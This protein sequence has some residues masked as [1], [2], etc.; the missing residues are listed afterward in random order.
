MNDDELITVVRD[1]FTSVHS[2]TPL[3][4]IVHRSH[5][6]RFR[7]WVPRLAGALAAAAAVGIA[8]PVLLPTS[9]RATHLPVV[10]L[11]AAWTVTRQA[12]GNVSVTIREFRDPAGLQSRLRADGVPASVIFNEHRLNPCHSYRPSGN[13]RQLHSAV[14]SIAVPGQPQGHAATI[15]IH[16]SALPNGSGVQITTRQSKVNVHLVAAN[17]GCTGE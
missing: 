17:S 13:L 10:Q 2:A 9:H 1:A 11:A 5:A 12:D 14:S 8:V 15:V 6:M 4:Q 3:Q 16:P 7:L